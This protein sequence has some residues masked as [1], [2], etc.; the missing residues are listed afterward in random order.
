MNSFRVIQCANP[1]EQV[2]LSVPIGL[3]A[4]LFASFLY[5]FQPTICYNSHCPS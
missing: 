1:T 4:Q 2:L 3:S 5:T